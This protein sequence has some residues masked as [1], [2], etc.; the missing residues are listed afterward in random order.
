VT[1]VNISNTPL[2]NASFAIFFFF[3]KIT[4]IFQSYS[5]GYCIANLLIISPIF[6]PAEYQIVERGKIC[7]LRE[8][9]INS[10]GIYE[11]KI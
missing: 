9:R 3:P 10:N 2:G 8:K 1:P 11:T 4:L 5:S 6:K 7:N